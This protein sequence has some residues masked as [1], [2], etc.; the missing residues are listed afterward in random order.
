MSNP[1]EHTLGTPRGGA[2]TVDRPDHAERSGGKET[3]S[4]CFTPLALVL[5]MFSWDG[6]DR[7]P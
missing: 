2:G 4:H 3:T 5:E 6:L 1:E 7:A